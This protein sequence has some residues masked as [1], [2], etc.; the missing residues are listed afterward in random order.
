MFHQKT[1]QGNEFVGPVKDDEDEKFRPKKRLSGSSFDSIP[2]VPR[3]RQIARKGSPKSVTESDWEHVIK[4]TQQPMAT[5]TDG[6]DGH[7]TKH[8]RRSFEDVSPQLPARRGS[9]KGGDGP[10]DEQKVARVVSTPIQRVPALKPGQILRSTK[11]KESD[12][13]SSDDSSSFIPLSHIDISDDHSLGVSTLHSFESI[14]DEIMK[15]ERARMMEEQL[16]REMQNHAAGYAAADMERQRWSSIE[17]EYQKD[18]ENQEVSIFPSQRFVQGS[19]C[20]EWNP[21]TMETENEIR[22]QHEEIHARGVAMAQERWEARERWDSCSSSGYQRSIEGLKRPFR[23]G[24]SV[25]SSSS[26]SCSG[27]TNHRSSNRSLST[28][29]LSTRNSLESDLYSVPEEAE[30]PVECP[31]VENSQMLARRPRETSPPVENFQMSAQRRHANGDVASASSAIGRPNTIE[32]T[33]GVIMPLRG[34]EETWQAVKQGNIT[35]SKCVACQQELCCIMDAE[36]LACPYC[37]ML[38]PVE[39][40]STFGPEDNIARFGVGVGLKMDAVA[41]WTSYNS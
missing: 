33:P 28:R 34:K 19:E 4:L 30:W 32:V 22:Q 12:Q 21:T 15:I 37:T 39:Q 13:S 31:P 36:L 20:E 24:R 8:S 40:T 16:Q 18:N 1:I 26:S 35:V 7:Q 27:S 11:S 5:S 41:R 9:L 2:Q 29:S 14:S 23:G 6:F 38:S 3:M 17:K 25:Q 10:D